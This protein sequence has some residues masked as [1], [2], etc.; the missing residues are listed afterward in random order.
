MP[1]SF[2]RLES[3]VNAAVVTR[4]S[5]RVVTVAALSLEFSGMFEDAGTAVLE[6]I[7]ESTEPRL[8]SSLADAQILPRGTAVQL[9][10]P[11]TL[12]TASY[13]VTR[14]EPDGAG[15][16]VYSLREA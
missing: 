3:R 1:A 5:N 10:N 2:A 6:G 13:E 16:I 12:E 7:V 4:L 8:T 11:A 15:F 9:L 14:S